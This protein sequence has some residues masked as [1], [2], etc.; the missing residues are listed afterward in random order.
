MDV[1]D[2]FFRLRSYTPIPI[3]LTIIYNSSP[4]IPYSVLGISLILIGE[5]I[6]INAVRFAGGATRTRNVGAPFLCTSGPY[7]RTRNPLY[8]GNIIIYCGVAFLGG[9]DFM[10]ELVTLV[11]I[12]FILQYYLIISLEEET[13]KLK[14]KDQYD[15]YT[16]NVPKL[17]PRIT[18]WGNDNE[19]KPQ[20]LVKTLKTEKRTLQNISFIIFV[21]IFKSKII[22]QFNFL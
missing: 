3:A 14:F 17:L 15:L 4:V 1:R 8:W 11:G 9:G 20:S 5:L 18:P 7:S 6:R 10:W 13:L 12:F 19:I 2:I 16:E 22:S 21:I